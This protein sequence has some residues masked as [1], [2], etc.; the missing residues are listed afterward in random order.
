MDQFLTRESKNECLSYQ[1]SVGAQFCRAIVD[2]GQKEHGR[3]AFDFFFESN[4]PAQLEALSLDL[5]NVYGYSVNGI[6]PKNGLWELSGQASRFFFDPEAFKYWT[7]D[8]SRLGFTHDC[9]FTDW[10]AL[11][12]NE[13]IEE[14]SK[15]QE[16]VYFDSAMAHYENGFKFGAYLDLRR[17][18]MVNPRNVDALYSIAIIKSELFFKEEA[19]I[20]YD[21]TLDLAPDFWAARENRGALR[22]D[23]G[24]HLGAIS[25]Y[26][27]VLEALPEST[28]ALF[29]R[30]NSKLKIGDRE[31]AYS[32][33]KHAAELGDEDAAQRL[34]TQFSDR[35]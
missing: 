22:D 21:K 16:D 30:G 7:M 24:D 18:L 19:L 13:D 5:T 2:R 33:W 28:I 25:D 3:L 14:F 20:D 29:N 27:A 9:L 8:M 15:N 34:A 10:G 6:K 32:D 17:T 26:D 11:S 1:L 4:L 31:G 12:E 23:L 35:K